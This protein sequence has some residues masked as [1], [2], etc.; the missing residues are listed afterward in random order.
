VEFRDSFEKDCYRIADS[1]VGEDGAIKLEHNL[2][3]SVS[4]S[5]KRE[6][7]TFSG[8]PKKEID[9]LSVCLTKFPDV[10]LL[11]S[12]KKGWSEPKDVQEW[13][14]VLHIFNYYT[15]DTIYLGAICAST[16]FMRGCESW[17]MSNNLAL[18]PPYKGKR[19]V[20]PYEIVL[21]MFKQ[22]LEAYHKVVDKRIKDFVRPSGFYWFSYKLLS[23]AEYGL[24]PK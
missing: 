3:L 2:S 21:I 8:P 24:S 7:I 22:F 15:D 14:N 11:V 6:L 23:E 18:I 1:V 20:Y 9:I 16:G 10:Y 19:L 13:G 4:F 12:C 5:P 17:A